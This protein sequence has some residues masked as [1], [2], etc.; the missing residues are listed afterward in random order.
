MRAADRVL[1]ALNFGTYPMVNGLTRLAA[2]FGGDE[3]RIEPLRAAP[4]AHAR[5]AEAALGARPRHLRARRPRLGRRGAH[6]A[7]GARE[8]VARRADRHGGQ[9]A[10]RRRG[11]DGD[12]RLRPAVGVAELDLHP[13]QRGRRDRARSRCTARG[14]KA[15]FNWETGDDHG[16]ASTKREDPQQRRPGRR[17]HAA[18]RA[19]ALAAAS[20][21]TGGRSIGPDRLQ[22]GRRL[23]AHRGVGRR[24]RLGALRLREDAGLP[25]GHLPRR[26][27]CPTATIGFGDAQGRAGLAAG[28]RASTARPCAA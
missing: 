16:A 10:L 15:Q 3:A 25:L 20:S 17:P 8:P 5:Y 14:T 26:R 6:R 11:D 2:R 1:G 23:P 22:R 9:P 27:R 24:R 7:R 4:R 13:A 18:A 21:S 12:A 28:A 19:R